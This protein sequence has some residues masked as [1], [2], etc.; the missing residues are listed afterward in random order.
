MYEISTPLYSQHTHELHNKIIKQRDYCL[1]KC[2]RRRRK[3]RA[4]ALTALRL[5]ASD[6]HVMKAIE[7][8]QHENRNVQALY[9]RTKQVQSVAFNLNALSEI[10]LR[11]SF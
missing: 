4:A 9:R 10:E 7:K 5:G 1:T 6:V 8:A 11:T 3:W 2:I